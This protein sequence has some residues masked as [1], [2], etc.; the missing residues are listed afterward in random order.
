M[1]S[2]IASAGAAA[3]AEDADADGR[4]GGSDFALLAAP[5]AAAQN[6]LELEKLELDRLVCGGGGGGGPRS[7]RASRKPAAALW[8]TLGEG[9][10]GVVFAGTRL[11][12]G[13]PCALK[14]I[15]KDAHASSALRELRVG[16]VL[17]AGSTGSADGDA[18]GDPHALGLSMLCAPLDSFGTARHVWVAYEK[19]GFSL[20]Q[21]CFKWRGVN[22]GGERVYDVTAQPLFVQLCEGGALAFGLLAARLLTAVAALHVLGVS[23]NDLKP[24][25]VLLQPDS[26]AQFGWS[27]LK[28]IDFG[29]A[30]LNLGALQKL[31]AE[32]APPGGSFNELH[33]APSPEF[34][35][36]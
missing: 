20:A 10:F 13:R 24:D 29:S 25:N 23:H 35:P 28:L 16:L 3:T 19:G 31:P 36:P 21:L 15:R 22:A 18:D 27:E 1:A 32:S 14:R 11:S 8:R 5:A 33:M 6:Y 26:S 4:V 12:D 34:A 9:G 17:N 30:T 2:S 7:S